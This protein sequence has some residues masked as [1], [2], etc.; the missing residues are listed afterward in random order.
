MAANSIQNSL[1]AS[2]GNTRSI[3]MDALMTDTSAFNAHEDI[4]ILS[5]IIGKSQNTVN[6]FD[7]Y[8]QFKDEIDYWD[9]DKKVI[10][11]TSNGS[12]QQTESEGHSTKN[13]KSSK[14]DKNGETEERK[15]TTIMKCRFAVALANCERVGL[16]KIKNNGNELM[17]LSYMWSSL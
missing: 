9:M 14:I 4:A 6:I 5:K 13:T 7:W 2:N 3:E 11:T 8:D 10:N 12:S 1:R 17:R 15:D 16:I